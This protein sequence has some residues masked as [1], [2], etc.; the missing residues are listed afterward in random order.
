MQAVT[1][2]QTPLVAIVGP[3]AIGKTALGIRLAQAYDGEIVSADSR[4]FYRTMDIG[5]AKPSPEELAAARHHLIDIA[6][7]DETVGLAQF[8]TLARN[9]IRD[10]AS[11]GGLPLVVG[12]TGQ[13]VRALLQGWQVPTVP[14]DPELR[15]ELEREAEEDPGGVW[16]RLI[17]LDPESAD[18]IDPRNLRRV[19]R[20]LEVTL[21]SERPFSELRR[22]I[23]PPYSTLKVGLTMDR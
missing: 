6:D 1:E 20:A 13:Y 16:Q 17:A 21:K 19:I 5:T 4:Q 18:F 7:P 2:D 23:P 14:P 10:I 15:A 12:G 3:T 11:R 22:R 9:A 8:L